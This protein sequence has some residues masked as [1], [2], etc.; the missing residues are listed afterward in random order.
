MN[1][2]QHLNCWTSMKWNSS[3]V[4][5]LHSYCSTTEIA[6]NATQSPHALSPK[7]NW[8]WAKQTNKIPKMIDPVTWRACQ[9]QWRVEKPIFTLSILRCAVAW[10]ISFCAF[11]CALQTKT[12]KSKK[13]KSL[14]PKPN[15]KIH[16]WTGEEWKTF[17]EQ[18]WTRKKTKTKN[19][20]YT[21]YTVY[22]STVYTSNAF[23]ARAH[24]SYSCGVFRTWLRAC[25]RALARVCVF[26]FI[27][28]LNSSVHTCEHRAMRC[29]SDWLETMRTKWKQLKSSI[30]SSSLLRMIN[31]KFILFSLLS[32]FFRE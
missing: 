11:L 4:K 14:T 13:K 2:N 31:G 28:R 9:F 17:N 19:T 30:I 15:H 32:L 22:T 29:S 12:S 5:W 23:I 18:M 26:C 3:Q 24:D 1:L 20:L 6:A 7:V 27:P 16:E 25:S 10:W 21:V 8:K